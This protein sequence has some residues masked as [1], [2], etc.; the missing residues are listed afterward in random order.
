L[1]EGKN[2]RK[3][4]TDEELYAWL[5]DCPADWEEVQSFD[6]ARWIKFT[7]EEEEMIKFIPDF[8]IKKPEAKVIPFKKL[9][10]QLDSLEIRKNKKPNN[11]D[12]KK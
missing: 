10:K 6:G 2:R 11:K 1:C 9:L 8:E 4:M 3:K 5:D 7:V 12:T